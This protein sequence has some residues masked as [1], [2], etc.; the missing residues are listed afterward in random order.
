MKLYQYLPPKYIKYAYCINEILQWIPNYPHL[1][2][3]I[4]IL[5]KY[6]NFWNTEIKM[7]QLRVL[8]SHIKF[9]F[10]RKDL[11][12]IYANAK[13]CSFFS[14]ESY[15]WKLILS[16]HTQVPLI[17]KEGLNSVL[18]WVYGRIWLTPIYLGLDGLVKNTVYANYCHDDVAE[19]LLHA[20]L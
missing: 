19:D 6:Y 7:S 11:L 1:E 13:P 12:N 8:F 3:V 4:S 14:L 2:K 20:L 15:G 18:S 17:S 9:V 10:E 5:M 16:I